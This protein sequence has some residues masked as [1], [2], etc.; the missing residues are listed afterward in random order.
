MSI[1]NSFLTNAFIDLLKGPDPSDMRVYWLVRA[2]HAMSDRDPNAGAVISLY[3]ASIS[4]LDMSFDRILS[5][6][7]LS[8]MCLEAMD[9]F[10]P[11]LA[12]EDITAASECYE[13]RLQLQ[14]VVATQVGEIH[15]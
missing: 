8:K 6:A 5:D 3:A 11:P 12:A 2:L 10:E 14:E 15:P 4:S 9:A 13:I 1:Q 7:F